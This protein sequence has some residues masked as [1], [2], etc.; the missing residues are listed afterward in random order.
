MTNH[1][2]VAGGNPSAVNPSGVDPAAFANLCQT[3]ER[4]ANGTKARPHRYL[5]AAIRRLALFANDDAMGLYTPD[6]IARAL[7]VYG[8]LLNARQV[9][10]VRDWLRQHR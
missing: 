2:T 7:Q 5:H 6:R 9:D 3:V 10:A 8:P 4:Y 1:R